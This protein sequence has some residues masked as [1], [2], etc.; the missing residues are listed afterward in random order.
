MALL[1]R[2][3]RD[4]RNRRNKARQSPY[5]NN[6]NKQSTTHVFQISTKWRLGHRAQK[7]S[8]LASAS[9]TSSNSV[10]ADI[11]ARHAQCIVSFSMIFQSASPLRPILGIKIFGVLEELSN[12]G[13]CSSWSLSSSS[14]STEVKPPT[15]TIYMAMS[16]EPFPPLQRLS[17][18]Y[19]DILDLP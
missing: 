15:P 8:K 10:R 1:A 19:N 9:V 4:G 5:K 14:G 2:R 7:L 13:T 3:P 6:I 12:V 16:A 11:V 18:F 17:L